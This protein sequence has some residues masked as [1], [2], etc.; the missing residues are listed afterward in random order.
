MWSGTEA[1][2]C[3]RTA[4][5]VVV[6][7]WRQR[8]TPALPASWPRAPRA[9]HWQSGPVRNP[10]PDRRQGG[11]SG[12]EARGR[13]SVRG[14]PRYF[15][16]NRVEFASNAPTRRGIAASALCGSRVAATGRGARLS[17]AGPCRAER[18]ISITKAAGP[19]QPTPCAP[20]PPPSRLSAPWQGLAALKVGWQ[21]TPE[22]AWDGGGREVSC[23]ALC[24]ALSSGAPLVR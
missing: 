2:C 19:T 14:C 8:R 21:G 3:Q 24:G 7:G 20:T 12:Q 15:H 4:V 9:V 6:G 16:P 13:R 11:G 17:L 18:H 1:V 23:A 10:R 22:R 5:I